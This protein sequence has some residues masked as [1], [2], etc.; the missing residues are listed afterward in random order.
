[1]RR[2]DPAL[3]IYLEQCRILVHPFIIGELAMGGLSPRMPILTELSALPEIDVATDHEVRLFVDRQTLFGR[4][5]G[6]IDAHLLTSVRL[7]QGALLWTKDKRL[8]AAEK[9]GLAAQ[10]SGPRK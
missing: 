7:T 5:L 4:G 10:P 2:A 9:S 1:M 8:A 3:V 6:Y